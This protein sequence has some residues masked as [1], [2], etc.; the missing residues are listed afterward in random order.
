M[1]N[2]LKGKSEDLGKLLLRVTVGG[3]LLFHG[4]SKL[5]HGVAWISGPLEAVGLPGFIRYGAYIGEVLA[6]VLLIIGYR[7]RLAALFVALDLFMAIVLVLRHQIFT[8][9]EAGGGWSIELEAFF[10]LT[11]LVIFFLGGGKYKVTG[12]ENAWD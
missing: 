7:A 11:A 1:A 5:S 3:L 6:P 2:F 10:I 8:I 12:K 9:K 4:V